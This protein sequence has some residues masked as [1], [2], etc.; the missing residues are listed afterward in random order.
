MGSEP[1]KVFC[2]PL[3]ISRGIWGIAHFVNCVGLPP[4]LDALKKEGYDV[5]VI[6]DA[7]KVGHGGET[8]MEGFEIERTV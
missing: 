4:Q 5:R 3:S 6:G 8:I 1:A 2:Q 7:S